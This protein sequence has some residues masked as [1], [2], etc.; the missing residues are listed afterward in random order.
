MQVW[1]TAGQES[2]KSI[3]RAYYK[4]SIAALLVFD[5]S[6]EK[7]FE[8]VNNWFYELKTHSHQKLNIVLIG[9]KKDLFKERQISE[10][11]AVQFAK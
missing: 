3:T 10:E 8:D 2:F 6:S 9:N 11:K 5:L 7:S 1:D 4:G